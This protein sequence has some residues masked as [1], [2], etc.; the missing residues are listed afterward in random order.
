MLR[1]FQARWALVAMLATA[2]GTSQ[3]GGQEHRDQHAEGEHTDEGVRGERGSGLIR[4]GREQLVTARIATG[5]VERRAEAGLLE[6][7]AEIEA[8]ADRQAR[9]GTRVAGR[10]TRVPADLGQ[11]VSR[12]AVLAV[13]DSPELGR[14]KADYL[15][16]VAGAQ[17]AREGATRD[18]A[19]FERGISA[20][21]EWR[22]SEAA[23]IRAEAEKEAAE[24]RLHALGV[25]EA[26]LPREVKHY[27][28]TIPVTAPI[29][30]VV[31]E[32][33]VTLGQMVEPSATLFVVMD[34]AEV[35]I[36]VDVYERDLPQVQVGQ[37]A[38]VRV[39]AYPEREFRGQVANIGAIVEPRT[40]AVKV[41]IVLA[42][43]ERLLKAGMFA[44][45]TLEGTTGQARERLL[46]PA[47]AIQRDG[48]QTIVFVPRGEGAFQPR[49]VK[50]AREIGD[51]VE[52]ERGLA[53]GDTVVTSGSFLLKSEL[54]KG[55]LGG[56]H[57]H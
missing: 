33:D 39:G 19:L 7:N 45:V 22:E 32:R 37:S 51:W 4:L 25:S 29:D 26:G 2:C 30:G 3:G 28:S 13:V 15:A 6:A 36:L 8:P 41:R 54:Q 48:E 5:V 34:L 18:K 27:T 10:V 46:A 50:V 57:D 47:A 40:R 55:E 16:A 12:G 11:S 53:A 21:R 17:V 24:N 35:W 1:P 14:A 9:V 43:P 42:N 52:I 56:G 38:R 31:V 20:E 23:A 44:T 49:Q